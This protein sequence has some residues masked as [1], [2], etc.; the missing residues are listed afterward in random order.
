VK[1]GG[2][3]G[4][5]QGCDRELGRKGRRRVNKNKVCLKMPEGNLMLCMLIEKF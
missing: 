2:G 3:Y 4:R 5:Y 1:E